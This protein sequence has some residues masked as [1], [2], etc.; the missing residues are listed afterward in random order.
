MIIDK[1]ILK[2][3]ICKDVTLKTALKKLQDN[4]ERLL[5][6]TNDRGNLEGVLTDGDIRSWLLKQRNVDLHFPINSMMNTNYIFAPITNSKKQIV[7]MLS[8]TILAIPLVDQYN[9]LVGVA[10]PRIK[11]IAIQNFVINEHS[12]T[13]IISEIGNNHNGDIKLARELVDKALEAGTDCVKFQLRDLQSLYVN[14]GYKDD[15]KEDLGTQY[16]LDLLSKNSLTKDELFEIFDYCK[17]QGGFP[18]CTPW[19]LQS[20]QDLEEYGMPAYKVASADLVNVD[21]LCAIARTGK[22]LI[23]STGMSYY[24]EIINAVELLKNNGAQY[25]LLQCNSAYPAPF[26]DIN[27]KFMKRL[28]KIGDCIVGYSGHERHFHVSI[29]AVALGAKVIEKHFTLDRTMEGNDH[30]ISLLPNEFKEMV[31]QIREIEEAVGSSSA[32]RTVSQGELMNR[33]IL[34]KSITINCDLSK[35]KKIK[36]SML[37]IKSPG[38]GAPPYSK[39]KFFG[40]LARRDYIAGDFLYLT[41]LQDSLHTKKIFHFKRKWGIPIRYHDFQAMQE[42]TNLKLVEFHFSYKDLNV[43]ISDYINGTFDIDFVVH[44]PELFAGEHLLDL[45]SFDDDYRS[46]SIKELQ[47]VIDITRAIKKYFPKTKKPLIIVNA[48]GFSLNKPLPKENRQGYYQNILKSFTQ[49]DCTGVE[50]IPQTMPPYPW[51]FGGQRFQNLFM[52]PDEI[53]KFCEN[54]DYRVCLDVSHSKLACNKH[55]WSFEKFI[56]TVGF[57]TAHLH[58]VDA[59]GLDGEGLQIGDGEID[60]Y[61]LGRALDEYAPKAS[62]IPEIW[63]G[64][65]NNGEGAWIALSRLEQWF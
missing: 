47:R 6:V 57:Y 20:L 27:L 61:A 59:K 35:G 51:H 44:A 21:L 16:T 15:V 11:E 62:F 46:R 54:Y 9:H 17:K 36:E 4:K 63:Q 26:K 19:D 33:E 39:S 42:M 28:E 10:K 2:Y 53:A 12:S 29:A 48:G 14:K 18:L 22:P 41:D 3:A 31:N 65:K 23:C 8:S 5:F 45:A 1:N 55:N 13:F 56:E 64:H 25:V 32:N 52:D 37:E 43:S 38:K 24:Q 60:F 58:I 30:R 50:L 49:L 40:K 34:G 7:K